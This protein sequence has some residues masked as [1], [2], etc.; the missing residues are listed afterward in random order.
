LESACMT[1]LIVEEISHT[2]G[3]FPVLRGASLT[4]EKGRILGLL[5]ASGSGKTTLLRVIAGLERPNAGKIAIGGA[6]MFDSDR[7]VFLPPEKRDVGLVFQSYALWPHR[8]V[9]QNVGYG[10]R[11]RGVPAASIKQQSNDMLDRLGLG[12]LGDRYPH[13]LSGGQQQRVALC[14]ALVYKPKV[15]LLDEPLSNLDAKLRD[16]ARFWIRQLILELGI[17]GVVVTHDQTEALSMCDEILLLAKGAIVEKGTPEQIYGQPKTLTAAEF[18]GVNNILRGRV[19]RVAESTAVLSGD[20][21]TL[22]GI[23]R[24]SLAVGD[25]AC[26]VIRVD[27]T[28]V[29]RAERDNAISAHLE[30]SVYL[31]EYWEYMLRVGGIQIRARGAEPIKAGDVWCQCPPDAVWIYP[32]SK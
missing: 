6:T 31:G 9:L 8:T 27:R 12:G 21:W 2:L 3:S 16:E 14:R 11:L 29:V 26:A 20:G 7:D 1:D 22:S 28:G 30:A 13:Q 5:G 19:E 23:Q 24:G 15:L 32:T 4:A 18:L 17:C 25:T 10:L